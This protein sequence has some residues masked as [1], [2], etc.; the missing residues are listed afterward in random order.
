M[1]AAALPSNWRRLRLAQWLQLA[2]L[3]ALSFASGRATALLAIAAYPWM[4]LALSDLLARAS[5]QGDPEPEHSP[6]SQAAWIGGGIAAVWAAILI[7]G[8]ALSKSD[9]EQAWNYPAASVDYAR[10]HLSR[11]GERG[12]DDY[13]LSG[14]LMLNLKERRL[15]IDKRADFYGGPAYEQAMN[16]LL[17]TDGRALRT[18]DSEHV[19][20]VI[21][22]RNMPLYRALK[23]APSFWEPLFEERNAAIFARRAP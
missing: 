11:L 17:D 22:R 6:L 19:D 18:L 10:A 23:A 14:Y 16:I 15:F 5:L 12:Y 9:I 8:P 3:T 1:T 21:T 20:W 2:A 13:G 7:H 4:A